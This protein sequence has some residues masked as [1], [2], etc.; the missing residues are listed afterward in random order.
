[1]GESVYLAD[2]VR[3][4]ALGEEHLGQGRVVNV[5]AVRGL[6]R[7]PVHDAGAKGKGGGEGET[8]PSLA[9]LKRG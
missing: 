9:R 6:R 7:D 2:G 4:V 5:E 8:R 3:L 1:M